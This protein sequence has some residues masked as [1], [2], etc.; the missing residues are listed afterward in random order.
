[1]LQPTA[2]LVS[3]HQLAIF[4]LIFAGQ[5]QLLPVPTTAVKKELQTH[6]WQNLWMTSS[7]HEQTTMHA[8]TLSHGRNKDVFETV[9]LPHRKASASSIQNSR[10]IL[11][12][13]DVNQ[14]K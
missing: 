14:N 1:M 12:R 8:H 4:G 7:V 13:L 11:A 9:Q 5:S 6:I 2:G 3:S 10:H